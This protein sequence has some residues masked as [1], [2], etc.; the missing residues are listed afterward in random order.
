MRGASPLNLLH[1]SSKRNSP[2]KSTSLIISFLLLLTVFQ[3]FLIH[4]AP[5]PPTT[6]IVPTTA[7]P[8]IQSAIDASGRG[9]IVQVNPGT[10][11]EHLLV[12]VVNLKLKGTNKYTTIIDGSGTGTPISLEANGITVTGFTITD[13]GTHDSGIK[14][15]SYDGHNITGNIIQN[16]VDGIYFTQSNANIIV[17]NTFLNNSMHAINIGNSVDNEITDNTISQGAFGVYLTLT[18]NTKIY[19]NSI[20]E[21]GFGIY[22]GQTTQNTISNN[23][24]QSNSCGIQTYDSDHITINN[25]AI[26]GGMYA[27]Q[28]QRTSYSTLANNTLSQTS[29]GYGIYFVYSSYNTFGGTRGNLVNKNDWGIVIYNGTGNQ[30]IDGNTIAQNTWGIS[31]VN[32]AKGNTIYHNNFYSNIKHV[33]QDINSTQNSWWNTNT[34]EGNYWND[35]PGYPPAGGVDFYPLSQPWPMRNLAIT[36]VTPSKTQFYPGEAVTVQVNV[37]NFGVI[38]EV[39]R[40]T[41]YYSTNI[42]GTKTTTLTQ[43]AAQLLTFNWNTLNIPEGNYMISA[44]VEPIPYVERDYTDN[45]LNDGTVQ[46]GLTGDINRDHVVDNQDL[47]LLKQAFG[48]VPGDGNWNPNADLN[49]D[50]Q[51]DTQDLHLLARNYGA[52][53]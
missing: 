1:R 53:T 45:T 46:V 24:L 34:L 49:Y 43:N 38:T 40:V 31:I 11:Y 7:Y 20:S 30:I 33:Y 15:N 22:S 28:L 21:T 51:I 47:I 26:T 23:T 18:D 37:K 4:D 2:Q 10:Y 12:N 9:D 17:G 29:H 32:Y 27:I 25:N 41:A 13:Q 42:I 5:P 8:T 3:T 50:L 19:R 36:S 48:A 35:Y 39:A 16:F 52:G 6:R 14:T 44:K